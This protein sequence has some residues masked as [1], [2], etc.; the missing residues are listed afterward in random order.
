MIVYTAKPSSLERTTTINLIHK[1]NEL[2]SSEYI[3][4]LKIDSTLWATPTKIINL[5]DFKQEKLSIDTKMN[6]NNNTPDPSSKD[7]IKIHQV[8]YENGGFY[9]TIDNIKGYFNLDDNVGG[10]LDMILTNDQK[11]KYHQ[12]WKE[13][14]KNVNGG[15]GELKLHEKI[16]LFDSNLPI[17]KIF[18]IPSITTSI[19]IFVK[20]LIEKGNKFY[21]ELALNYCLYEL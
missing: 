18:K 7:L 14:F 17:G 21:L 9:L 20:S 5:L 8:R 19:T 13:V 16:R 2:S 11:N 12:V 15:N 6:S 3:R 4:E 1:M 10:I